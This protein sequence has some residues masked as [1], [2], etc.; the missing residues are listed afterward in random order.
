MA[1]GDIVK[2]VMVKLRVDGAA[3]AKAQMKDIAEQ[4]RAL[5]RMDPTISVKVDKDGAARL[6][7]MR[8]QLDALKLAGD[9]AG[10]RNL[11]RDI[12]GIGRA[13]DDPRLKLAAL[14]LQLSALGTAGGG[15]TAIPAGVPGLGG[16][17]VPAAIAAV[18]A[19]LAALPFLAQAAAGALT[20]GLGGALVAIGVY[21]EMGSKGVKKQLTGLQ[22]ILTDTFHGLTPAFGQALR[23]ILSGAQTFLPQFIRDFGP[24]LSAIAGPLKSL[25]VMFEGSLASPQVADSLRA[26]GQAFGGI[27]KALTPAIPGIMTAIADG[28]TNLFRAVAKNPKAIADLAIAL[29]HLIGV[30]LDVLAWLTQVADYL[31]IHF[32]GAWRRTRHDVA[33]FLDDIRHDIAH[34]ARDF[35]HDVDTVTNAVATW[36]HDLVRWFDDVRHD[37]FVFEA[38]IGIAMAGVIR[39]FTGLPGRILRAVAGFGRLLWNAGRAL[40][41][42]LIGGI[43]SMIGG[44]ISTVVS[45]GSSILG[46]IKSA[47]GIGSPSRITYQ[48]GRWLAEGLALGMRD[49]SARVGAAAM[50]MARSAVPSGYGAGGGVQV[51]LSAAPGADQAVLRALWPLIRAEVR[52]RGG[53]GPQSVQRAL[54]VVWR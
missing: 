17:S 32:I 9:T 18:L 2:V 36:A 27:L 38:G 21:A 45:I 44:L 42:G 14:R 15:S 3:A 54:G 16:M 40:L 5:G 23:T 41:Q 34:W 37:A 50:L 13:T 6:R 46:H 53:G 35:M 8:L 28:F 12:S 24:A 29:G 52:V 25:A 49:G 48:H 20:F 22:K 4:A 30:L 11:A 47:L 10:L 19:G 31:E 26:L 33:H 39:W 43:E 51:V 1:L 7:A